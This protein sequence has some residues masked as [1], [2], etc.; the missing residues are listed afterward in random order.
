MAGRKI[1]SV[2]IIIS[3]N[4]GIQLYINDLL[5]NEQITQID[6]SKHQ[7]QIIDLKLKYAA[8]WIFQRS[9]LSRYM[10]TQLRKYQEIS[11]FGGITT[12]TA[13]DLLSDQ[14]KMQWWE[15]LKKNNL[16]IMY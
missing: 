7:L 12:P 1:S 2:S 16:L 13:F 5:S 11:G 9:Y 4:L 14:G 6:V 15:L 3:H 8:G 10:L